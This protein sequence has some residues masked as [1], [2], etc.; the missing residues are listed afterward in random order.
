MLLTDRIYQIAKSKTTEA[1]KKLQVNE[2]ISL[3]FTPPKDPA[4]GDLGLACHPLARIMRKNPKLIAEELAKNISPTTEIQKV[5]AV[6][7]YLNFT[8]NPSWWLREAVEEILSAGPKLGYLS[9]LK[10]KK[11]LIEFSGPN[12][13]KPQHL[14]HARNNVIGLAISNLYRALGAEVIRVNII[15]DRGIHIC[16]SMLA[17]QLWGEGKT[18]EDV[19]RK[20]DFFV[21]DF[22]VLF[23]KKFQ[24]EYEKYLETNPEPKLSK[25]EFFNQKSELGRK[26]REL[27]QRWEEGDPEVRKL[28]E[29]MNSWVYRG[30]E[31]TYSRMGIQ[32]DWIDYE[33]ETYILG[34]EIVLKY[35]EKGVFHKRED[36][37]VV[38]DLTKIGKEGEKVLLRSDGTSVYITQD[39]GTAL[40]RWEK[41]HPD[42]MIYVVADEQNY[43]FEILFK[44]LDLLEEKLGQ[45]CFHLSYGMVDLPHGKMKSREGTVVDADTLMD[46]LRDLALGE[47][48]KRYR[49]LSSEEKLERAEKI[50]QA[51]LKFFLLK[52]TPPSRMRF[53]PQ[54]SISFEGETGPYC[55]YSYARINSIAQK[56]DGVKPDVQSLAALN[57]PLELALGKQLS[58]FPQVL[59][60]A[61]KGHNPALLTKYLFNLSKNF[62]SFYQDR[63][64]R[65]V[66]APE[67]LRTA[68]FTLAKA[69]QAVLKRGLEI[70][71]IQTIEQM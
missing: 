27:L 2:E 19:G 24:E 17:Y 57:S 59:R 61:V 21:G 43:H 51:G 1:L 70:L 15:N 68:R 66:D 6:N 9:D 44:I 20:G 40:R 46:E 35:L 10:D 41:F 65:I 29:K 3:K 55:L 69:V 50:G 45:K 14:G 7:G 36:G 62:S 42:Q 67:P 39:I 47:I 18:P 71:G 49:D 52:F 23:E 60:D 31:E 33:S 48:E 38:C 58:W 34:K 26:A 5:E 56:L 53:N 54:Q 28:W 30:F 64:H 12:T 8:F 25:D 37:A 22:Y 11:I 13:N 32:F 16:K 4:L 63:D